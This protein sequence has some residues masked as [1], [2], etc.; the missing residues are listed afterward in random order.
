MPTMSH[1]EA[2]RKLWHA[3]KRQRKL[4]GQMENKAECLQRCFREG[5]FK[6]ALTPG[7]LKRGLYYKER[8]N[9]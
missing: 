3:G 6:D 7:W 2:Q 8:K 5:N 9:K 1:T 4:N